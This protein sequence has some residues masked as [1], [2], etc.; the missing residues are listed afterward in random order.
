MRFICDKLTLL[1]PMIFQ[2]CCDAVQR[3][4]SGFNV[5]THGDLWSNNIM[6]DAD[7]DASRLL[8]VRFGDIQMSL[9]GFSLVFPFQLDFQMC[10]WGSPILDVAYL[11]FT[12]AT[13]A[14]TTC[15]WDVLIEYY[16]GELIST[17]H[18]LDCGAI[19][20]SKEQLY[21]QFR[22]RAILGAAFSLFSVP[23]RMLDRPPKNAILKFLDISGEGQSYRQEIYGQENTRKLLK[24][25][26]LY[27]DEN[28]LLD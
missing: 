13:A 10:Y 16:F 25:L 11:L 15:D 17:L 21:Q 9:G 14:I 3:D 20:P 19:C 5:L 23:M 2:K 27:F 4:E 1:K 7:G 22:A 26:L 8:F 18:L 28:N 12:S 6:F 24:N